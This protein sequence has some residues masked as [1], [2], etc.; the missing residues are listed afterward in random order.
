MKWTCLAC[1]GL[2]ALSPAAALAQPYETDDYSGQLVR[3]EAGKTVSLLVSERNGDEDSVG[4]RCNTA[5]QSVIVTFTFE[6]SDNSRSSTAVQSGYLT[7]NQNRE[8]ITLTPGDSP[9]SVVL[10]P[11][12]SE[13]LFASAKRG[14]GFGLERYDGAV[15]EYQLAG[16]AGAFGDL[17]SQC[18]APAN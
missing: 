3:D 2:V 1:L 17:D 4:F 18:K 11:K 16:F 5:D 10:S 6:R 15:Q 8:R 9:N 14:N 7:I 13:K 12:S